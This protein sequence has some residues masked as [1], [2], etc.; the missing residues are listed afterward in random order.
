LTPTP[1]PTITPTITPSQTGSPTITATNTPVPPTNTPTNT[2]TRTATN[3][4]TNT[5]APNTSTPTQ[6]PAVSPSITAT[7]TATRT[8]TPSPTVTITP[9]VLHHANVWVG[10]QDRGDEDTE[11]D[12]KAEVFKNGT[13]VG[14]GQL[15]DVSGGGPGIGNSILRSIGLAFSASNVTLVSGDTLSIKLSVRIR[16]P[17]RRA[18]ARLWFNDSKVDSRFDAPINGLNTNFYLR[19]GFVLTTTPGSGPPTKIDVSAGPGNNAFQAF[20]S[21]S[22]TQP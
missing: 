5:P 2:L 10:L 18:T 6:T 7:L 14:A 16:A 1:T 21:W 8:A 12:L 9:G 3:T 4:A 15:N 22:F 19:D 13:L 11:F 20:G 17:D